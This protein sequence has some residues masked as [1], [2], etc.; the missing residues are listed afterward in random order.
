MNLFDKPRGVQTRWASFEN[1][2]AE[3][4][5]G[6]LENKG[7][8]GHPSDRLA[9]GGTVSLLDVAGSG[10]IRRIWMTISDRSADMLRSLRVD[11]FW[12]NATQPAVSCPLGDFFGV[13]LGQRVRFE[14]GLFS[15]PEGRSFNCFVPMPFREAARLTLTNESSQDL[16]NLFYDVD[17]ELNVEHT[18]EALYF[19]THWH[20]ESPNELG[21]E[22]VILPQVRGSGRF[23]GCNIGVITDA[24]YEDNWWGEGE[25]KIWL[26]TDEHPTLCGTGT[27]DYIGTA[28]GQGTYA[29]RSQGCLVADR[30]NGL[31]AF[32]RYHL[33]D[34]VY[35]D[36]GCK[37]A[38]QTIGGGIISKVIELQ[39]KGA[40]LIPVTIYPK[41]VP[42]PILLLDLPQPVDLKAM[43]CRTNGVISGGRMIGRPPPTSIL[44][45]QRVFSRTSRRWSYARPD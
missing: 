3:R 17:F 19:H 34:A 39:K 25:V 38:I 41:G 10:T 44:I 36:G 20:R 42:P 33:D 45:R 43:A 5:R 24:I 29:H 31:W 7:G 40:A 8:K 1:Q 15:D 11:M 28:W 13:G 9:A 22:F 2:T 21:R 27:E 16:P 37:V 35:F 18:P 12:D 6:G 30:E 32:Y 26:G 4:N 23:L 14:S